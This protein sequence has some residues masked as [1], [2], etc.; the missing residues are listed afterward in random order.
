MITA[1]KIRAKPANAV[2]MLKHLRDRSI[3]VTGVGTQSHFHLDHP[4]TGEVEKTITAF[5][6]LGLKVMI[7]E[8]DVEV[9]PRKKQGADLSRRELYSPDLASYREGLPEEVQRSLAN[10]YEDLFR[11]YLRHHQAVDRVTFWG[12][13][14]G[15]SWL[16]HFLIRNRVNH[17]LFFDRDRK[18]KPAYFKVLALGQ[19]T[20]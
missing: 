15:S 13:D 7:T 20:R 16:N 10:R 14:D 17:P 5:A 8:L 2:A 12:L 3:P 19:T 4:A 11:I 6:N 9:L 18:P 1:L